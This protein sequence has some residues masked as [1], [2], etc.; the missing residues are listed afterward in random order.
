MKKNRRY[1]T[2]VLPQ[3]FDGDALILNIVIIPRNRDP[4]EKEKMA[5]ID[6]VGFANFHPEFQ[7]KIAKDTSQWPLFEN[8][9]DPPETIPV[10]V[11]KAE[12]KTKMLNAVKEGLGLTINADENTDHAETKAF[13]VNKYLPESYRDSFNFTSPRVK[14][15]KTDDSY[16]CLLEKEVEKDPDWKN[17]DLVSWGTLFANILRQPLLARQCGMIYTVKISVNEVSE[18]FKN[19]CY[20]WAE[21]TNDR[22]PEIQM[23][24]EDDP[25]GTFIKTYAARMPKL[26]PGKRRPVFAPLVIP[27]LFEDTP[28]TA[29]WDEVFAEINEYNDG[30]SKIV[31]A[32][33]PV[34]SDLLSEHQDGN[35]PT[36]DEGIQLAWDDEQILIWY[37]RQLSLVPEDPT[38]SNSEMVRVDVPMGVFGYNIDVREQGTDDWKS[39]N[40]VECRKAYKLGEVELGNKKNDKLELPYQVYPTQPTNNKNGA[41]WL[42]MYFANWIGKSL[43]LQDTDAV[44]IF[45]NEDANDLSI[46][47]ENYFD[48]VDTHTPLLYGNAYEFRIRMMDLSGGGPDIGEEVFNNAPCPTAKVNFRRY[49]APGLCKIDMKGKGADLASGKLTFFNENEEGDFEEE[50]ELKIKRPL[51]GYPAVVFSDKYE[52]PIADLIKSAH[53]PMDVETIQGNRITP[54]LPDPDVSRIEIRVEVETLQMDNLASDEGQDNYITLYRTHRDF[55]E[56]YYGEL[57]IPVKFRDADVLNLTD[58]EDPF[59]DPNMT[60]LDIDGLDYLPLPTAR[61]VRVSLRAVCREQQNY[62]GFKNEGNHDLDSR[63]GII[64]Q[65]MFFK[66][67]TDETNLLLPKQNVPPVQAIY[68]HPEPPVVKKRFWFAN[69]HTPPQII[70]RLS[71]K[72]KVSQRGMSLMGNKGERVIFGCS[73]AIQH[74]LSPDHSSITFGTQ[75]DLIHHWLGCLVFRVNRDW[76]WQGL[77]PVSF[78]VYRKLKFIRDHKDADLEVKEVRV[79]DLEFKP[80]ASFESL[81]PD[82]FGVVNREYTT[83]IFIDAIDPKKAGKENKPSFPD[84]LEVEYRLKAHFK[85]DYVESSFSREKLN[86]PTTVT[87]SQTPTLVSVGT[88]FSPYVK[89]ERYSATEPRQRYLWVE[90][91]EPIKDPHDTLFCRVL[92]YGPDQLLADNSKTLKEREFLEDTLKEVV[93]MD[94]GEPVLP[95]EP[96]YI[97][98]ITPGQSDDMAGLDAMQPME[99]AADSDVHYLLPLPPGLHA[100]SPELFGFF[101]YEFRV[102]HTHWRDEKRGKDNLWSTAQ[103]RFGRRIRVTGMQHPAP[104]LLCLVDR[105]NSGTFS[106]SAHYAKTVLN[107][108]NITMD[109][110]RTSLHAALYAQVRQADGFAFRNILL[111]SKMME[112]VKPVKQETQTVSGLPPLMEIN[113]NIYQAMDYVLPAHIKNDTPLYA[114]TM[115]SLI[116]DEEALQELKLPRETARAAG[117]FLRQRNMGINPQLDLKDAQQVLKRF[118]GLKTLHPPKGSTQNEILPTIQFTSESLIQGALAAMQKVQPKKAVGHWTAEEINQLLNEYGLPADSALSVIVVEVFGKVSDIYNYMGLRSPKN[119]FVGP[120]AEEDHTEKLKSG[121]GHFRILRT[122]PLTEV[123]EVCCTGC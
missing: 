11:K 17:S 72:L 73:S 119:P 52:D 44:K 120:D 4:F 71:Q 5:G 45:R 88:A 97:R 7:L 95:I 55:P 54:G 93:G 94:N 115:L 62:Y 76:S 3:K 83:L 109:P 27:V 26:T 87:P 48:E 10:Q 117:E 14:N 91:E 67:A 1:T 123:P 63:Y 80:Y 36:K 98:S 79:G 13:T 19:G 101:T 78:T 15:A 96:E 74:S 122:S 100:E 118:R 102:G 113:A 107:G 92:N 33:Q 40:Q 38:D 66:E 16:Q 9:A 111:D 46:K 82:R 121:L 64:S 89:N 41:F 50:T 47:A 81:T 42:P 110:P 112:L 58:E 56:D 39:L 104:T 61:K 70:Q 34:S 85:H 35:H 24:L 29:P 57:H 53:P 105:D 6:T 32:S 28:P 20:I 106:V 31:H 49:V 25:D 75:D 8:L 2:M 18:W 114:S 12:Q 59:Y 103:G 37:M 90:L 99:K 108:K 21:I 68:M 69:L 30:F 23:K 51:L 77:K 22:I 86:L 43:V 84:Q 60:N 65:L 116:P